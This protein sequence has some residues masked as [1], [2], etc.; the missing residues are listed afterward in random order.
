MKVTA[1]APK[2]SADSLSMVTVT[3]FGLIHTLALQWQIDTAK[4][5]LLSLTTPKWLAGKLEFQGNGFRDAAYVD[6]GNDRVRWAIHLRAP[7][8]GKYFLTATASLP[9]AET[10]VIAPAIRFESE[11]APLE[12]QRH[13]VLLIN[14]SSSQLTAA[15]TTLKEA[16]QSQD[17]PVVV[18]QQFIDQATELVRLTTSLAAPKWTIHKFPQ[19]PG[20]PASINVADLTTVLS[21]DGTYRAQAQYTIKNRTRQFLAL[22]MPEGTELLSVFVQGQP[23][24]RWPLTCH[25]SSERLLS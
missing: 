25:R 8:S 12:S 23:S 1:S 3:D 2:L 5:D 7:V 4:T 13:Y 11:S 21:R 17:L 10:E 14:S 6:A 9:P 20:V 16:V 18:E 22:T 24:A 15:D 19:Q